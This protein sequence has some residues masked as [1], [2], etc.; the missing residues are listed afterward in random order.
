MLNGIKIRIY[1]KFDFYPK[2]HEELKDLHLKI[3]LI[4]VFFVV[5][6]F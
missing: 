6:Y 2:A 3:F 5:K 1:A 4:F